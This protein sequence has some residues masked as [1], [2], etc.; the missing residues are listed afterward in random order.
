MAGSSYAK[1]IKGAGADVTELN[2]YYIAADP[3][4]NRDEIERRCVSVLTA[5]AN[6]VKRAAQARVVRAAAR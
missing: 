5:V 6:E 4:T 3:D 2:T 1:Q